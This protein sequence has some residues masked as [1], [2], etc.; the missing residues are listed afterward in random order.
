M[1]DSPQP[2][3]IRRSRV[4]A[5]LKVLVRTRVS[6]GLLIF[7]PIFVTF[8]L[9]RFVFDMMRDSTRWIVDFF[10]RYGADKRVLEAWGIDYARLEA[11]L[12]HPPTPAEI[13][14]SMPWWVEFGIDVFSVLLALA[15][16]Y[17]IGLF[18]AN[19]FG[20]RFLSLFDLLLDKVPVVKTVYRAVKQT[21][22]SLGGEQSQNLQRVALVPFFGGSTR[23]IA[24]ITNIF[25]D[26][27]SGEELCTV[28][29][30]TTPNPTSGFVLV[31]K[32]RDLIELNWTVEEAF[33]AILSCGLSMPGAV[34]LVRPDGPPPRVTE[35]GPAMPMV[36]VPAENVV[37][38]GDVAEGSRFVRAKP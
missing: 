5:T 21:M 14:D 12:G 15:I 20:K 31:C 6:A 11:K 22:T 8:W 3:P 34:S 2:Q 18:A 17:F 29:Y 33:R 24:F 19:V 10:L 9:I 32:R 35:S 37:P 23:T 13:V 4:W 7:L 26:E 1:S 30:P 25:V 36:A 28:F 38:T 16:L 27:R